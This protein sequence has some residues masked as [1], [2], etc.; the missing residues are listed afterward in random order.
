[1]NEPQS[2]EIEIKESPLADENADFILILDRSDYDFIHAPEFN[3]RSYRLEYS[4]RTKSLR[5][6]EIVFY[7]LLIGCLGYLEI[8]I[9]TQLW[10][11]KVML[12]SELVAILFSIPV[13]LGL[14]AIAKWQFGFQNHRT[15]L[16]GKSGI[17]YSRAWLYQLH[18]RIFRPWED[19]YSVQLHENVVYYSWFGP[20]FQ[21]RSNVEHLEWR[22]SGKLKSN[23]VLQLDYRS[24]GTAKVVLDQLSRPQL[25]CLFHAIDQFVLQSK[26]SDEVMKLKYTLLAGTTAYSYTS[27]WMN[28]LDQRISN[29][30][31]V[32]LVIG[33]RLRLG[34]YRVL[35]LLSSRGQTATYFGRDKS[36][37]N[38]IL[39]E[40]NTSF[41]AGE[42]SN[43]KVQE[44]FEREIAILS[45]L[46][47]PNLT[48]LLD[49]ITEN[50]RIYLVLEY[51]PGMT[52]RQAILNKRT[53]TA[54]DACL[55]AQQILQILL[56]LHNLSPAVIH[57]DI[58]P[59]NIVLRSDGTVAIIDF[60]AANEFIRGVTGT[61]V[62]KQSYI[63]PEQF[64]GK[65]EPVSDLYS[66]GC[67]IYYLLN[68]E[69]P[70]PL[71]Q[72]SVPKSQ[73]EQNDSIFSFIERCTA[74][75][76]SDRFLNAEA[77]LSFLQAEDNL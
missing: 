12:L 69:D 35:S 58:T 13:A 60:G 50:S 47:H 48:K 24:G 61:L 42:N 75:E 73:D 44:M 27:I 67:V 9:F 57:R 31:F 43:A 3:E 22:G 46:S 14:I 49:V 41:W 63:A 62:G 36:G 76:P 11:K 28:G 64:R 1:M 53:L 52:L 54:K 77:A 38:V 4:L 70:V 10:P 40:L 21:S 55:I 37:N 18:G 20:L 19:L 5:T 56:Y 72:S 33:H 74:F 25:I 7:F 65:A 26:I 16:L 23:L 6:I 66:L 2:S 71:S 39:K 34:A 32:P 29:T 51:I 45:K 68:G 30:N 17:T 59:D 15:L 8:V